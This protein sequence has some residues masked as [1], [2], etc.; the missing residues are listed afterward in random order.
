MQRSARGDSGGTHPNPETHSPFSPSIGTVKWPRS[1]SRG[2]SGS[3]ST[4]HGV[5]WQAALSPCQALCSTTKAAALQD[6]CCLCRQLHQQ[7]QSAI[8][9]QQSATRNQPA[10]CCRPA[11]VWSPLLLVAPAPYPCW[12]R[13]APTWS[14]CRLE[15]RCPLPLLEEAGSYLVGLQVGGALQRQ[16]DEGEAIQRRTQALPGEL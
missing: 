10:P 8:S 3:S 12:R 16:T 11:A 7:Q 1:R 9:N 15:E 14:G 13:Q 6:A 4:V 5:L 2:D